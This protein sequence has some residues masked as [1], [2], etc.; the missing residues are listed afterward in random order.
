MLSQRL[1]LAILWVFT[2][3]FI[4]NASNQRLPESVV[5]DR[6]NKPERPIPSGRMTEDD[7]RRFILVMVP[8]VAGLSWFLGVWQEIAIS[9]VG[10]WVYNDLKASE[11]WFPRQSVTGIAFAAYNHGAFRIMCGPGFAPNDAGLMWT[12]LVS[13]FIATTIQVSDLRDREGDEIKGRATLPIVLGD[14][15]ARWSVIVPM[16]VWSI[17]AVWYTNS[18]LSGCILTTIT[19]LVTSIRLLLYR[20]LKA[21]KLNYALWAQWAM[22]IS[23]LPA[24]SNPAVF[25]QF[26][27]L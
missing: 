21:D 4:F 1:P 19:L 3:L 20:T 25:T 7:M 26:W 18:G 24:I 8:L 27:P 2:Q 10:N 13:F 6:F 12:F 14:L 9:F 16:M 17:F 23:F 5:E 22:G 11:H 15:M